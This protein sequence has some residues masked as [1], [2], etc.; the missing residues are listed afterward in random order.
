[1]KITE[2][3]NR[4]QNVINHLINVW[5]ASVRATHLFLSDDEINRIKAYVPQ[6]LAGVTHLII[7]EDENGAPIAFMGIEGGSLE[8]LFVSPEERGKGLGKTLLCYGIECYGVERLAVN[9]QNP[10]AKGF[11]V[12]MGF[13]VY[14]RTD[15][16]EQGNPYPLLYMRLGHDRH[17]NRH[18]K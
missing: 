4:N 3:A 15:R 7:A 1:M 8:M 11:Y 2:A 16:D 13:Q 5:E 18:R 9:E 10:Q 6:A 17:R 12:H 14:K